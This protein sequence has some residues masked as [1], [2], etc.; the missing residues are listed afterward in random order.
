MNGIRISLN[1]AL[2]PEMDPLRS[3]ARFSAL[4]QRLKLPK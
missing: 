2:D 1:L 4:I 3:D